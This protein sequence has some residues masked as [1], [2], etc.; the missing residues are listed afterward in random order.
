MKTIVVCCGAGM[1]TSSILESKVKDLM[2]RSGIEATV[3][4]ST[5]TQL[6]GVLASNHVDLVVPSGKYNIEGA[7]AV[8]GMPYLIG[9]GVEKMEKAIVDALAD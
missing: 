5:I 7:P 3:L 8:S 4:K 1:A 2:K 6:P 9:V